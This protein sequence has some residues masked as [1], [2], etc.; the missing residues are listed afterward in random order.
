MLSQA[1]TKQTFED[2]LIHR[3]ENTRKNVKVVF[4]NFEKFCNSHFDGRTSE[5]VIQEMLLEDT[6]A[7]LDVLQSWINSN[8]LTYSTLK[9]Y[10]N[11]LNNYLYYR[12]VKL[13]PRDFKL[14]KF[15]QKIEEEL[16]PI[17]IDEIQKILKSAS[18]KRQSFYFAM[19]SS[20][21]RPSEALNI[22]KKDIDI[23]LD[24]MMIKIPAKFTK[25]KR[26]RT[27]FLNT[28][29]AKYLKLSQLDDNS[30]VWGNGSPNVVILEDHVFHDV[31]KNT[32]LTERY[33]SNNRYKLNLYNFRAFFITKGSRFDEN[34]TKILA[35][36]RGYLL[37]YDRLTDKEKLE[38]YKKLEP[39]LLIFDTSKK[40]AQL[41]ELEDLKKR[42]SVT[43]AQIERMKLIPYKNQN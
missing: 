34:F 33:E 4:A 12:G 42:L 36:Q 7:V 26:A 28:E 29:A 10:V 20:G 32:G 35:G 2:T 31:L 11:C 30:L 39:E 43:E 14:L 5:Q 19:L 16:H 17:S 22:K 3:S 40:D 15:P 38:L 23:S 1:R 21:M 18:Y 6:D 41:S 24:R 13:D 37:Q 8:N 27:T 25:L 9:N